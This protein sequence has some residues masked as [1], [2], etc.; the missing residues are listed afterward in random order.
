MR[1]QKGKTC[2][3]CGGS[4]PQL[5]YKCPHCGENINPAATSELN[6]IIENLEA[7]LV[8]LKADNDIEKSK[9][10]VERYSRKARLYY[11][12]N[13]KIQ[14]LLAEVENEVT[15]ASIKHKKIHI[16]E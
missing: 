16:S 12:N 14:K 7:S 9:A 4:V 10:I 15:N 1:M 11:G 2:P 13:P 6:E 8:E 3:Y 5:T